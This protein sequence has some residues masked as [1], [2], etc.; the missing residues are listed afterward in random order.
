[1]SLSFKGLHLGRKR[2]NFFHCGLVGA[3]DLLVVVLISSSA[4]SIDP[5]ISLRQ[6]TRHTEKQLDTQHGN[7]LFWDLEGIFI[8]QRGHYLAPW[9]YHNRLW[10][11][12]AYGWH[13]L[14]NSDE[15]RGTG[16]SDDYLW[17]PLDRA[18]CLGACGN[19]REQTWPIETVLFVSDNDVLDKTRHTRLRYLRRCLV[20]EGCKV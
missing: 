13:V 3:T 5:S 2:R 7:D 19:P 9:Y 20:R 17:L 15:R 11:L 12:S 4:Y 8:D 10:N 14:A 1:M 16:R 18:E 6:Y